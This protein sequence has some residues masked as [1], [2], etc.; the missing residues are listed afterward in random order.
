VG[1]APYQ[2]YQPRSWTD[3]ELHFEGAEVSSIGIV[4][5]SAAGGYLNSTMLASAQIPEPSTL[6]LLAP[7]LV[8][9]AA[10]LRK[11]FRSAVVP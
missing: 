5:L 6:L 8:F 7:A 11:K 3:L 2:F 4:Y 9:F 1:A 10:L